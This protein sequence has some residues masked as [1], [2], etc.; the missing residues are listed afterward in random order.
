[1][2]V[3]SQLRTAQSR[4][5]SEEYIFWNF[6]VPERHNVESIIEQGVF[7]KNVPYISKDHIIKHLR[8]D[9]LVL[10]DFRFDIV[11]DMIWEIS[12]EQECILMS[13][14]LDGDVA[15]EDIILQRKTN[16]THGYHNLRY[17]NSFNHLYKLRRKSSF[18]TF[19]IFLSKD[20]YFN[21][22]GKN[23]S[24]HDEFAR[25]IHSGLGSVLS[26]QYMPMNFEMESII[27]K[28]RNCTRKGNFHRLCL[29]IKV[30]ELLLHQLEQY[31]NAF[32]E[33]K[34]KPVLHEDD[35]AKIRIAKT[36]LEESYNTPPTI[37][38]LARMVGVNE[39][40]LK[41]E[42]KALFQCTIHEYVLKFRMEKANRLVRG[43][44]LQMREVAIEL[45][46]KNPSHFSAAFKKHFGFLPT[47]MTGG[48]TN[49]IEQ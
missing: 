26:D 21:I 16:S 8:T 35:I 1:M 43:Q 25:Q 30:Q 41:K 33:V 44:N 17:I 7:D 29:E 37:K 14:L 24:I 5:L 49:Y 36:I 46:Y 38:Q 4:S 12:V 23:N 2:N 48:I 18:D 6:T 31:H 40:K 15:E 11:E 47:E 42:F 3:Y 34:Q 22:I 20:F 19:C 39:F 27:T 45:G 13:F 10:L 32:V 9:G 28:V